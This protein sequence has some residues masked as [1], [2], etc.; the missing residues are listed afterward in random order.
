[1]GWARGTSVGGGSRRKHKTIRICGRTPTA[2]NVG[3]SSLSKR[4]GWRGGRMETHTKCFQAQRK[5]RCGKWKC[6]CGG[7]SLLGRQ[8]GLQ[9]VDWAE[10]VIP[11]RG[12]AWRWESRREIFREA[13]GLPGGENAHRAGAAETPAKPRHRSPP[14]RG[15]AGV[16]SKSPF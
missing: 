6:L 11:G 15:M 12:K 1:M 9:L 14:C 13:F 2:G 3:T 10:K 16:I 5:R 7:G 4:Q 8:Q